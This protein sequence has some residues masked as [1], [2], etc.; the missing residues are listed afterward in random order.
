MFVTPQEVDAKYTY[1]VSSWAYCVRIPRLKAL[2][3]SLARAQAR[4]VIAG[5]GL[6]PGLDG[7]F[8]NAKPLSLFHSPG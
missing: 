5:Q 2:T 4:S 1:S 8:V 6:A 7:P 3:G